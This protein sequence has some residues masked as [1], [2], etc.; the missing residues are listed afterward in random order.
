MK[1][2]RASQADPDLWIKRQTKPNGEE[3]YSYI[4]AYVDDLLVI[5]HNPKRVM[6]ALHCPSPDITTH[7]QSQYHTITTYAMKDG[8]LTPRRQ[9]EATTRARRGCKTS[10]RP[11][12]H[13]TPPRA[14]QVFLKIDVPHDDCVAHSER[15]R[16]E[17]AG[18]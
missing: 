16:R 11:A 4:L 12:S 18:L 10:A 1:W 3:Y 7:H 15:L 5:H 8:V 17:L 2:D 6:N 13:R 14:G 9:A